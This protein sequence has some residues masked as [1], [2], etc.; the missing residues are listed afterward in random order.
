MAKHIIFS[1]LSYITHH[2]NFLH[3]SMHFCSHCSGI[4]VA[5][6]GTVQFYYRAECQA[7]LPA[8]AC[9]VTL[10]TLFLCFQYLCQLCCFRRHNGRIYIG[11][12]IY[13]ENQFID[14]CFGLEGIIFCLLGLPS[15]E[16]NWRLGVVFEWLV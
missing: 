13:W 16:I 4:C 1:T 2:L 9:C 12:Y 15:R 3:L 7:S 10:P 5:V 11:M 14:T 6:T 8:C